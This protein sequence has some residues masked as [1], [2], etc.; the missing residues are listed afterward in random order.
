MA[1]DLEEARKLLEG[2]I[3]KIIDVWSSSI[4]I[5]DM[6]GNII[7]LEFSRI[8]P[9]RCPNVELTIEREK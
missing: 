3:V 9:E 5:D 8:Y 6:N 4:V 1:N 7:T 2:Q